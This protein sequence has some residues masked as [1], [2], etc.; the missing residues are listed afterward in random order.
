MLLL[1]NY[2]ILKRTQEIALF[3]TLDPEVEDT[4]SAPPECQQVCCLLLP[5]SLVGV[6]FFFFPFLAIL[7][8]LNAN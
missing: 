1:A 4:G 8:Q 6:R 2:F 3:K 5:T 7:P